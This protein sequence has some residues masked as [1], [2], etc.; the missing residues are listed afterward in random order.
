MANPYYIRTRN[1]CHTPNMTQT[2][3]VIFHGKYPR[4]EL[5]Y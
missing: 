4:L 3:H 1:Q 2:H 5:N